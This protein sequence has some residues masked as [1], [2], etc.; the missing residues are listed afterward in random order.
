VYILIQQFALSALVLSLAVAGSA[1]SKKNSAISQLSGAEAQR[2]SFGAPQTVHTDFY[3]KMLSCWF[4]GQQPLLNGYR[5][6]TK[7]GLTSIAGERFP[8]SAS[9][10]RI[11]PDTGQGYRGDQGFE[12]EFHPYNENTLISTRN[13]SMPP[14]LAA[15]L[16]RDIE[17]WAF[18][19]GDCGNGAPQP[20][21]TLT[22]L[23]P[24]Q[25]QRA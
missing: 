12:V 17:T 13:L 21:D 4:G 14:E 3:S 7:P 2:I 18:G 10:I 6:D 19:R 1:C 9:A 5:T 15:K 11:F 8:N 22:P 20:A 23:P 16:R 25:Y 24:L